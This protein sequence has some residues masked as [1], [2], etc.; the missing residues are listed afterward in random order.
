TEPFSLERLFEQCYICQ[1]ATF[2]RTVL[3]ERLGPFD[4]SLQFAM[5]YDFWL[6]AACAG[7]KLRYLPQVLACNRQYPQTKT[8]GQ[9]MEV[10]EEVIDV[11]RRNGGEACFSHYIAYWHHRLY[12]KSD[13][14]PRYGRH[15]PAARWTLALLH[16]R[17]HRNRGS[18]PRFTQDLLASAG[19][20]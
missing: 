10:L 5:D 11:C 1:P 9:R 15:L 7:E 19:R 6:R 2:W 12:E 4:E 20:R 17:W 13:G 16:S 8:W 3:N 14:W 18:W